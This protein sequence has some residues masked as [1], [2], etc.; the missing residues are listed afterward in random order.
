[1]QHR[2]SQNIR[3]IH[4]A[5]DF[6][7]LNLSFLVSYYLKFQELE[8]LFS[9]PYSGLLF[10][11]NI[12]WFLAIL[13]I[14]PYQISRVSSTVPHILSKHFTSIFLH[15]CLIAIFFVI[16]RVYYYSREQLLISYLILFVGASFWKAI[17]T[18]FLRQYRIQGYNN[19]N[20]V[21]V[22][23]GETAEELKSFFL[24]HREYGYKFLGY[25]SSLKQG[26]DIIGTPEEVKQYIVQKNVDEVYCCL[27]YVDYTIVR[28][29]ID[30][31]EQTDRKVKVVTDYRSFYSK[32]VS[33]ERY[34]NIPIL[35]ISSSP[36]EDSKAIVL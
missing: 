13:A 22:G 32:G 35:N 15:A 19:R 7:L 1:M 18:Y 26:S 25:F 4:V 9:A 28:D 3:L 30:F 23:Y 21:V 33:L 17:F 5:V 2:F 11:V 6:L 31:C 24:R 8:S 29:I 16:F 10:F 12:A 14:R 27:P 36:I 20:V 34:D